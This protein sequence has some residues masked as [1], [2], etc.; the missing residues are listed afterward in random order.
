MGVFI[1][2]ML[3]FFRWNWPHCIDSGELQSKH[4][5]R[6]I[7]LILHLHYFKILYFKSIPKIA[8]VKTFAIIF[9]NWIFYPNGTQPFILLSTF[10]KHWLR[11]LVYFSLCERL[12]LF[13]LQSFFFQLNYILDFL[14]FSNLWCLFCLIASDNLIFDDK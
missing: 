13:C 10:R 8:Q 4:R 3:S 11:I 7:A 14:L 6:T 2:S 9:L 5:G 12:S 1:G